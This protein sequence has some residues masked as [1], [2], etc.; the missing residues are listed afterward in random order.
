MIAVAA[1]AFGEAARSASRDG[2]R[3]M[4]SGAPWARVARALDAGF[5][6]ARARGWTPPGFAMRSSSMLDV[7]RTPLSPRR[8]RIASAAD[9]WAALVPRFA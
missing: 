9:V 5:A 6:R 3:A 2:R 1:V 4:E 8:A 7:A